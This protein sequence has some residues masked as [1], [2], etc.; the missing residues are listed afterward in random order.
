MHTWRLRV[1][2]EVW[3]G[4]IQG[5]AQPSLNMIINLID[6]PNLIY[7][8]IGHLLH[9]L[10]LSQNPLSVLLCLIILWLSH[11][12]YWDRLLHVIP[13]NLISLGP[14]CAAP[15]VVV[16]RL[17]LIGLLSSLGSRL[18]TMCLVSKFSCGVIDQWRRRVLEAI[19]QGTILELLG[20]SLARPGASSMILNKFLLFLIKVTVSGRIQ[21]YWP[22][23]SLLIILLLL[24]WRVLTYHFG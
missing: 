16:R 15:K 23:Q 9:L 1:Y 24:L 11:W 14:L 20:R 12:V 6:S 5:V 8:S 19:L 21:H 18:I 10:L 17:W 13:K 22:L 4:V 2:P 3:A 7:R